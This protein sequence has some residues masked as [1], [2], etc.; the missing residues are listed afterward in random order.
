[1]LKLELKLEMTPQLYNQARVCHTRMLLIA[2][3]RTIRVLLRS[4]LIYHARQVCLAFT[5]FWENLD[6]KLITFWEKVMPKVTSLLGKE[7]QK[8]DLLW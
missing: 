3:A 7:K 6:Q 1:M 2:Q 4:T 5:S 8:S